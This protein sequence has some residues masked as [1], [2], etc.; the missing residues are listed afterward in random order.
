M[1]QKNIEESLT[2]I[3]LFAGGGGL[4]VGLKRSGFQVV[5]AVEIAPHAFATYKANH[6]EVTAYRQDIRTV[7]GASLTR[8]SPTGIVDLLAGCPPCQ[9]FSSLT[10]KYRRSDP[11][12]SLVRE[13]GRLIKEVKPLALMMENVPGLA[14]KGKPLLDELL[15]VLADEGYTPTHGTLQVADFGIPQNRRRL[16]LLAGKGFRIELPKPTH[17]WNGANGLAQWVSIDGVLKGLPQPITLDKAKARGGPTFV[18][19]HVVRSLSEDNMRRIK[20]AKPGNAWWHG[21]PKRLRP[22]CHKSKDAG[23]SNVYGRMQWG[24]V[25]PTITGGCTTFSK[26]RF[27]HP[28]QNRTI[29]VY[30]A[31][32]LQT[33]PPDYVFDTPFMEHAC[34]IVGNALPCDFAEVVGKC[35]AKAIIAFKQQL[36]QQR[37]AKNQAAIRQRIVKR[38]RP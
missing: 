32:L 8:C 31:A 6:V 15:G 35:C 13:M 36:Q 9:G 38:K 28:T 12:N 3:D 16:V 27:G 25:S 23:F 21:I 7:D 24:M 20:R 33:F 14:V 34:D 26:G 10:A 5:S 11:R 19:W 4:T 1:R 17:S 22:D 29:S 30:E 37:P 18:K 2:A